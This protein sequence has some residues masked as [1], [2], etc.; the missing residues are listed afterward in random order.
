RHIRGF[1]H[2]S[3]GQEAITAGIESAITH[4][5]AIIKDYRCHGFTYARGASA[6]S[7]IAELLGREA[8]CSKGRGGSMHM[9]ASEFYGG[10]GIVGAGIAL[11]QKYLDQKAMTFSFYGYGA[12]NKGQVFEAYNMS[13]LWNLPI[14]F[15]CENIFGKGSVTK[16]AAASKN[17]FA[18]GDYITG[19]R[20]DG[21]DVLK[22]REA[23][24]FARDWCV[25][26]KGP[27]LVDIRV[28]PYLE[29]LLPHPN[30]GNRF[31]IENKLLYKD[32]IKQLKK[33]IRNAR[34][35]SDETLELID[36]EVKT[37]IK[38]AVDKAKSSPF[39]EGSQLH[40]HI[41]IKGTEPASVRGR[42]PDEIYTY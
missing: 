6:L 37:E 14:A 39:P 35:T 17:H 5:D 36:E 3:R 24:K 34:V 18:P 9:F 28:Y 29:P 7:I 2:L 16:H 8:G 4:E 10:N 11:K 32:P 26:G 20:V 13:K 41:Y 27:I 33:R 25:A 12:A 19:L 22:V 15:T 21:M 23:S 42:T 38:N 1:C 30:P 40:H 31:P